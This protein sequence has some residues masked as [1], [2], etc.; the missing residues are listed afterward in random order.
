MS[1]ISDAERPTS[2]LSHFPNEN[3]KIYG[4]L[5]NLNFDHMIRESLLIENLTF[6]MAHALL[7][8]K[9]DFVFDYDL[10]FSV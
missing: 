5:R 9:I 3:A 4:N 8:E 10:I 6:C 1:R 2:Y 7:Y